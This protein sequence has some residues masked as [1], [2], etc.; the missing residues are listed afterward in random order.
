MEI[1]HYHPV[2]KEHLRTSD[3]RQSPKEPGTFLV[4]A[5][6]TIVPAGNA[7]AGSVRVFDPQSELWSSVDDHRG[8]SVYRKSDASKVIVDWLGPVGS[9]YTEQ[10]PSSPNDTWGGAQWVPPAPSQLVVETERNRRL[11]AASFDYDFGDG[12][13]VHTIGTD[14]KDMAAWIGEVMPI[15][16]A[17]LALSDSTAINIVTNTGTVAVSPSEWMD[18]INT[19]AAGR[20]AIWQYYFALIAM[21]PIPADYQDDQYWSPPPEPEEE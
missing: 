11:A 14:E 7:P 18:I 21:D 5:N 16:Q 1:Y 10:V 4:P 6:A 9:D 8:D 19:G 3:A 15:A 20:Q 2:T 12:R 17:R 13:G